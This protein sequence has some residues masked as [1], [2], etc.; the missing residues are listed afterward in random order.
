MLDLHIEILTKDGKPQFA[1]LPYEEYL[2][3]REALQIKASPT[4]GHAR[5]GGFYENLSA[6]ELRRR[7]GREP[8]TRPE[9]L[10]GGGDSADWDGFDELLAQERAA[11]PIQ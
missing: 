6:E 3:V 11:H 1:V 10:Y 5:Y 2:Q 8:V 4:E 7:Q 9:H